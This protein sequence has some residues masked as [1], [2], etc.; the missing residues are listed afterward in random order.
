MIESL[1]RFYYNKGLGLAREAHMSGAVQCLAQAVSYDRENTEAWNLAGLCYY[2]LGQ[3][4]TAEYCWTRSVEQ[5]PAANKAAAYLEDLQGKLEEAAPYFSQVASL[6]EHK[7]YRQAAG[8]LSKEICS[9]FD[10]SAALLNYQGVLH[11]LDNKTGK[12]AKCWTTTLSIDKTNAPALRYLEAV[13][14]RLSYK[15]L[16][17]VDK[18]TQGRGCCQLF[19]ERK[20]KNKE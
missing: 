6:C 12:A 2:R 9:R 5:R 15:L 7:K 8:I 20:Q 13:E 17:W 10:L 4:K 3:Y 16:K 14:N 11:V 18:L 1:S 19:L